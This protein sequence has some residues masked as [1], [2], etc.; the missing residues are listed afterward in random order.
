MLSSKCQLNIS[1]FHLKKDKPNKNLSF[2]RCREKEK[3]KLYLVIW[4]FASNNEICDQKGKGKDI[5]SWS[6]IVQ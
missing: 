3:K 5:F 1:L 4:K 2:V 6:F